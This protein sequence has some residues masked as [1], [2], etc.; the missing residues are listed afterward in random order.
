MSIALRQLIFFVGRREEIAIDLTRRII[1]GRVR[2]HV[3]GQMFI[4]S[5]R[6]D[7]A[8]WEF[9]QWIRLKVRRKIRLEILRS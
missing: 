4:G 5:T 8:S 1:D 3:N 2:V 7:F 9:D 6:E